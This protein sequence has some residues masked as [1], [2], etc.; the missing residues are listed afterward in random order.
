MVSHARKPST[1]REDLLQGVIDYLAEHGIA[2]ATFRSL[3]A[4]LNI[5]TYPLVYYFGSKEQLL[6][7]VVAEVERRQR[8]VTERCLADG[9]LLSFWQWCLENGELLRLD[10]EILL[11]EGRSTG[12]G[13][14]ANRVFRDWHQLWTERF[15]AAGLPNEEA[16]V[17]ASLLV[18][19][20]VGL[21]LDLVATGDV[22]RTS[23][24][25]HKLV[26]PPIPRWTRPGDRE[27]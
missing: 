24:A 25:F 1:A 11:D 7:A 17:E 3:A 21:Q 16:E 5:S 13:P 19:G 9:N 14:L 18:G 23:R 6:G 2:R 12:D 4:W 8:D 22:D 27:E 10:F 15:V 26:E 20:I